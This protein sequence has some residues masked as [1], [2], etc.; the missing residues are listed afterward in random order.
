MIY[1]FTGDGKGKTTAALGQALRSV[2]DGKKV[3]MIQFIKGPW[4]SGEDESHKRLLPDFELRK[5]GKGFVGILNDTLPREEHEGAAKD[6]LAELIRE[7]E[8]EQWNIIIADEIHNAIDLGLIAEEDALRL[9]RTSRE[10]KVDLI[11]TGRGAKQSLIDE[12][13]L[14]SEIKDVKHPFYEGKKARRG[15]EY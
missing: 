5:R 1:I 2:G 15:I 14:V 7:V 6:A 3:L 9:I 8:G 12:A 4:P 11:L 10:K 13:D